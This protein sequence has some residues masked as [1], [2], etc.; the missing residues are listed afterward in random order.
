LPLPV[1]CQMVPPV[2]RP[3]MFSAATRAMV[4]RMAKYC[5]WRAI[6]LTPPS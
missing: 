2:R 1:V 6:F 4:A 3:W 5:W